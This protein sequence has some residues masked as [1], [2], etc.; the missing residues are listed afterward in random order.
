[1]G[2]GG[3]GMGDGD[4]SFE[5]F[6]FLPRAAE[7][8]PIVGGCCV[9]VCVCVADD[10]AQGR[11]FESIPIGQ[12]VATCAHTWRVRKQPWRRELDWG[13]PTICKNKLDLDGN[14]IPR[15]R[16]VVSITS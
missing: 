7:S 9:R 4:I 14:S 8:E 16:N 5:H 2:D 10:G 15:R 12:Q 3:W 11:Q 13:F 6:S 1:M